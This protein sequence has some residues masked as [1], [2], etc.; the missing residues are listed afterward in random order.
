M[1]STPAATPHY[2]VPPPDVIAAAQADQRSRAIPASVAIA[3]WMHESGSGRHIPLDSNNYWGIK[4]PD[5]TKPGVTV[6][7]TEYK[8]G[9]PYT[10]PQ[11]FRKFASPEEGW[12]AHTRLLTTDPR[13]A[14]AMALTHDPDA[15]VD[16]LAGTYAPGNPYYAQRIKNTMKK[17]HLYQ[18]NTLPPDPK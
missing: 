7:T 13:Y 12:A 6:T 16:A 18:Y 3:Q 14:K 5:P 11:Y 1:A 9:K 10:I 4:E 8:A 17:N 15:F 2:R